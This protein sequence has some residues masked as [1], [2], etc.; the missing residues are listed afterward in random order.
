[1]ESVSCIR[2]GVTK[3]PKLHLFPPK[4]RFGTGF[5]SPCANLCEVLEVH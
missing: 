5:E 1:M 2:F 3:E 4:F